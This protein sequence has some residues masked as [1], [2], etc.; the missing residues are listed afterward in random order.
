MH[1]VVDSKLTQVIIND[2]FFRFA[3]LQSGLNFLAFWLKR[4][5]GSHSPGHRRVWFFDHNGICSH[6]FWDI[7]F[8]LT[9]TSFPIPLGLSLPA[10][11]RQLLVK[12]GANGARFGRLSRIDFRVAIIRHTARYS[13]KHRIRVS[14]PFRLCWVVVK[15]IIIK[16]V[17]ELYR[18]HSVRCSVTFETVG[19]AQSV[20]HGTGESL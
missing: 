18:L 9:I 11:F 8:C 16:F 19:A 15:R 14:R 20:G 17:I 10:L 12:S 4:L 3:R 2:L 5:I 6:T 13:C 1:A 7:N